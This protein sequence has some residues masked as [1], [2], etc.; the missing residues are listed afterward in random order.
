MPAA[1]EGIYSVVASFLPGGPA[2]VTDAQ[3][4]GIHPLN[5]DHGAVATAHLRP[6]ARALM[7]ANQTYSVI[8]D[9]A[10]VCGPAGLFRHPT[11]VA[12]YMLLQAPGEIIMVSQEVAQVG[13]RRIYLT[14]HHRNSLLPTW[15]GES[16]GHWEGDSLVVDTVGFNDRSWLGTELE[17]HTEALH[18]VERMRLVRDGRYLEIYSTVDDREALSAPY[19]YSRYYRRDVRS[20]EQ[21]ALSCNADVGEQAE[22]VHFRDQ[23]IGD[24]AAERRLETV[25]EPPVTPAEFSA[26]PSSAPPDVT[27]A[28][29]ASLAP[30][31][32]NPQLALLDGTYDVL[33]T[34]IPIAGGDAAR[35]AVQ[36][37]AATQASQV[38]ADRRASH[39]D[40]YGLCQPLGPFRMMAQ[41]GLRIELVAASDRLVVLFQDILH[42]YVRNLYLDRPHPQ[43]LEARYGG[44]GDS[45]AQWQGDTLV[46]DTTGFDERTWLN[47]HTRAS[48]ALHLTE[49]LRP[50]DGGR[51]L[52]YQMTA[53]DP[54]ALAAP[55]TY[56][57]YFQRVNARIDQQICMPHTTWTLQDGF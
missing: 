35:G 57:R 9:L 25:A 22:W 26:A 24:L 32:L 27:P 30:A 1:W 47:E 38:P 45:I 8:D 41:P 18:L 4:A 16:I 12:G 33:P 3:R 29:A 53:S 31:G 11:T 48:S 21:S 20:F 56:S 50:I 10:A 52:A 51:L 2:L 44:Q 49:R 55:Y 15:N 17:P 42:G 43:K 36:A 34:D 5:P 39:L 6:W 46:V 14:D 13:V 37:I 40:P 54:Q 7:Q 23:A 28:S 19:S